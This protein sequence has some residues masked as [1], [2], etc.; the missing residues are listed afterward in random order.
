MDAQVIGVLVDSLIPIAAG[1]V[2]TIIGF[3]KPKT[4]YQRALRLLGP[5][6][7]LFGVFLLAQ[8]LMR[9]ETWDWRAYTSPDGR[10]SA[11]LPGVPEVSAIDQP[12]PVGS[13]TLH[14]FSVSKVNGKLSFAMSYRVYSDAMR[15]A[16]GMP[17]LDQSVEMIASANGNTLVSRNRISFSGHDGYEVVIDTNQGFIVRA[18]IGV[19]QN[20]LY[21]AMVTKPKDW[22]DAKAEA[23]FLDSFRIR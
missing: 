16:G 6:V 3:R 12:T 2:A 15:A 20:T 10:V 14:R 13:L 7:V 22:S 11:E 19:S 17:S 8:G 21:T 18:R 9:G 5:L 4:G 1:T 23:R